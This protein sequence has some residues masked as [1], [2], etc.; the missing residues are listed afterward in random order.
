MQGRLLTPLLASGLPAREGGCATTPN[1]SRHRLGELLFVNAGC[2]EGL[3][4]PSV[5]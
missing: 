3:Q 5:P 2:K 1:P 4:P